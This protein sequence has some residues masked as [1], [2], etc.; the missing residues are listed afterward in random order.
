MAQ[1]TVQQI[2]DTAAS[3]K[4]DTNDRV[5]FEEYRAIIGDIADSYV[6]NDKAGAVNGVATLGADGKVPAAQLPAAQGGDFVENSE[7]GAASG[8]CDL[9][10][11]TKVPMARLYAGVDS[12]LATLGADGKVPSGQLPTLSVDTSVEWVKVGNAVMPVSG[13]TVVQTGGTQFSD[14]NFNTKGKTPESGNTYLWSFEPHNYGTAYT[15]NGG[16]MNRW[17]FGYGTFDPNKFYFWGITPTPPGQGKTQ[18]M[19]GGNSVGKPITIFTM[20]ILSSIC[21]RF[22]VR[23][24]FGTGF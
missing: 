15:G 12:G 3:H 21:R 7:V 16:T 14:A 20:K 24:A 17:R 4:V 18:V 10:A 22:T 1:K 8:V 11:N 5:T 19:P 2:K 13:D 6:N 9:D 23:M